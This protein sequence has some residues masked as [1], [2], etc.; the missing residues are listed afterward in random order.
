[1]EKKK[2]T[3]ISVLPVLILRLIEG[4]IIIAI[5]TSYNALEKIKKP[6]VIYRIPNYV[7]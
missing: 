4:K 2:K 6:L 1:M 7:T 3:Q 5:R